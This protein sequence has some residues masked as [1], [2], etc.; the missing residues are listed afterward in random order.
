[1]SFFVPL[2]LLFYAGCE[3]KQ[4][5]KIGAIPPAI[6]GYDI[7]GEDIG[8]NKLKGKVVVLYFWIN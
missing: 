7:H 1:M 8:L 6:S 2:I 5:I 4:P 3:K